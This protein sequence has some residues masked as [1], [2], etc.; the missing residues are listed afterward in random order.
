M[1]KYLLL[2]SLLLS[3][4]LFADEFSDLKKKKDDIVSKNPFAN[5]KANCSSTVSGG[6]KL[7]EKWFFFS[8]AY[9][10]DLGGISQKGTYQIVNDLIKLKQ[11]SSRGS[12]KEITE[13]VERELKYKIAPKGF[14]Y[15]LT[16]KNGEKQLYECLWSGSSI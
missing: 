7:T 1:N 4:V 16:S 3:S 15:I 5:N 10:L 13:T 11:T 8:D 12:G 14:D 6:L 2:T 9:V